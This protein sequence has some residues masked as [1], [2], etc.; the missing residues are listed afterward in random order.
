MPGQLVTLHR[1]LHL[2]QGGT[3]TSEIVQLGIDVVAMIFAKWRCPGSFQ[4]LLKPSGRL[5][6]M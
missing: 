4:G 1:N 5:E 3:T 2:K 6:G